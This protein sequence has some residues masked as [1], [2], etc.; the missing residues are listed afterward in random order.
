MVDITE[1]EQGEYYE[2]DAMGLL[3]PEPV[4]LLHNKIRKMDSGEV[5][6]VLASD[7]S[8]ERDITRFCDFLGHPLLHFEKQQNGKQQQVY[9]YWV[10]KK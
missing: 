9:T 3:C 1:L 4:M 7:P 8:T 5:I 2:L 6:R 10:R